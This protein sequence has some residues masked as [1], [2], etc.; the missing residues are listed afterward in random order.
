MQLFR[1]KM[2]PYLI[3][4]KISLSLTALPSRPHYI[5]TYGDPELNLEGQ[6]Q[7]SPQGTNLD[8]RGELKLSL[9]SPVREEAPDQPLAAS[10]NSLAASSSSSIVYP[11]AYCTI[12]WTDSTLPRGVKLHL[13]PPPTW[14][15]APWCSTVLAALV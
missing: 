1:P 2:R 11:A 4:N 10:D 5:F 14:R 9:Q 3:W 12:V 6:E 15:A 7:R 8:T 13:L